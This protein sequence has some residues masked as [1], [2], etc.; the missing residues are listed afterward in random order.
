MGSYYKQIGPDNLAGMRQVEGQ[1]TW[2]GSYASEIQ[3]IMI[4]G[5][6]RPGSININK[7]EVGQHNRAS[8]APVPAHR[9]DVRVQGTGGHYVIIYK[10]SA[11]KEEMFRVAEFLNTNEAMEII[12]A[13]SGWL[14]GKTDFLD[15]V[16][17]NVYPGL[18]FYFDSIDEATEW[19]SPARCPIT[20][21]ARSQFNELRENHFRE[22]LTAAE[23]AAEFQKR[24]TEEFAAAG[25]S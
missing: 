8:W 7:P 19:S 24:C 9:S 1:G 20:I 17:P 6:W 14:P 15:T 5:Y 3:A 25:F 16:D 11:N 21:F 2:G 10:E 22:Q 12:F 23:A 4:D 18:K 13:E